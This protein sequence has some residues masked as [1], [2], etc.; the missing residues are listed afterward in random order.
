MSRLSLATFAFLIVCTSVAQRTKIPVSVSRTGEDQVGS[1]FVAAL[2][3][4]L[5]HS[6]GYERMPAAGTNQGL[7][8]YIELATVDVTEDGQKPGTKSAISVVIEEMGRPNSFPVAAMWYHK[9]VVV[10]QQTADTIARELIYD[11]DARWCN[12]IK[13]SIGRCPKEKL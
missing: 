10:D 6:I 7:R 5:G 3:R 2:N 13:S 8:F 11:M 4:E 1:R 12:T 9:I